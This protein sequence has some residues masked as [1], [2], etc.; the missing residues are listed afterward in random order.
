MAGLTIET[1]IMRFLLLL[2]L[3]FFFGLAFE[4]FHA[5]AGQ[6]RPGGVRTFPLLAL[7][8]ALLYRLDPE[9]LLPLTA[10]VLV[11]GLWLGIYYWRHVGETD[12]GGQP[13]VGIMVLIC[14]MLALLL[15]PVALAEPAWLAIGAAVAAVLLLTA[16]EWLHGLAR[17]IEMSEFV[18]AGKFL[19]LTGIVLPLLPDV[20]VSNLTTLTPHQVWLAVLA[21]ATVSYASYLLQR[22]LAPREGGLWVAMLGG[23]YSSTV[24]TLV[25]ARRAREAAAEAGSAQT[26]I[27]LASAVMYLRLLLIMFVFDRALA[28]ALAPALVGLAG[29]AFALAALWYWRGRGRDGAGAGQGPPGN[30]LELGAAVTFAVLFVAISLVSTWA[31]AR[32]GAMGVY[33]VAAVVG[34]TDI[35]PFVL[36]LASHGAGD[37]SVA[38]GAAAVLIAIAS[39][40]LL[41][42]AYAA[43]FMGWR[44]GAVPAG[45]LALLSLAGLGVAA[46][47]SW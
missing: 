27:I 38:A 44:A 6:A 16:R 22:Y 32:Y 43:G 46:G 19:L 17:R 20:P 15:G 45:A 30:P 37:V 28:L 21:V 34:V 25:L 40:N 33:V 36:N 3:G 10:G 13:N 7:A 23:L 39:N 26:G 2:G 1:P 9:R 47:F 41:K 14:N 24:T 42:A 8:G 31:R 5:Q 18:T 29:L 35:D 12:A 11:L 4:E